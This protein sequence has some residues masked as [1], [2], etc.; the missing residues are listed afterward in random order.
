MFAAASLLILAFIYCSSPEYVV[1]RE[2]DFQPGLTN[3]KYVVDNNVKQEAKYKF[4][5]DGDIIAIELFAF[6][7]PY[8]IWSN[9]DYITVKDST[10]GEEIKYRVC[11]RRVHFN[12]SSRLK[13]WEDST[14]AVVINN[15]PKI[16][17]VITKDGKG[18]KLYTDSYE[19]DDLGRKIRATRTRYNS[20][21][22]T[23]VTDEYTYISDKN[24]GIQ[25]E[26]FYYKIPNVYYS[27]ED[28]INWCTKAY[29][30]TTLE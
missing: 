15:V 3:W 29:V 18:N 12:A 26:E 4:N 11:A 28:Y 22:N 6:G 2:H 19:Y 27:F 23:T 7:K 1:N 13:D 8:G 5:E 16:K 25:S 17:T 14:V 9:L 21:G 20:S 30:T 24:I 10:T